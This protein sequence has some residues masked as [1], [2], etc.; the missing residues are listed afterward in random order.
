MVLVV[1]PLLMAELGEVLERDRFRRYITTE[2]AERFIEAIGL[3]AEHSD[4]TP[5]TGWAPICRDPDD[6]YLV[7]LA[8]VGGGT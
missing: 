7:A 6:D 8:R 4:A 2:E 3:L 5:T 1:S